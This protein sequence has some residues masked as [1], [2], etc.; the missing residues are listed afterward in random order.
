MNF[1][2]HIYL[3]G[4]NDE[5]KIG[6][7]IGDYIKGR[8]YHIYPENIKKGILLHRF[9]DSFTDGSTY[10]LDA[11]QLFAPKY[12][13]YAGIVIDIVYDH[14]LASNWSKYSFEPLED[15]IANFHA[16]LINSNEMLPKAVQN[17]VPKLIQN[18]RLYSYREIG[19]I[20]SVLKT[21]PK[22]TTLPDHTD[23]AIEVLKNNYE[24]LKRNFFLFFSDIIYYIKTVHD[25]DI[26][27]I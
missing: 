1:L 27:A 21:M 13:K 25:I 17:F 20:W 14:F 9:I 18:E 10:T 22:Y 19:G 26:K 15:F 12:R 3:S 6:N 8:A 23:F 11:K 5:V 4:N 7:F 2:A 24:F 16:L